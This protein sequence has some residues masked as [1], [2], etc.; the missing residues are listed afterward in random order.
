V[1]YQV[2]AGRQSLHVIDVATISFLEVDSF[3]EIVEIGADHI[4]AA[5]DLV[6][7]LNERVG[8]VA[9]EESGSPGNKYFHY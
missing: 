6:A 5:S 1:V 9:A 3:G 7:R 4:V 8:E 2:G